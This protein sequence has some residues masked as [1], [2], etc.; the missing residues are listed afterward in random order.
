MPSSENTIT[1]AKLFQ[2]KAAAEAK[3]VEEEK[4][5]NEKKMNVTGTGKLGDEFA[6]D[7]DPESDDLEVYQEIV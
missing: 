3:I 5:L 7:E 6:I 2:R 1:W 4:E